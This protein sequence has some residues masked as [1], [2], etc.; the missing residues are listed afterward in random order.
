MTDEPLQVFGKDN[1]YS[2]Y[3]YALENGLQNQSG[4][5]RYGKCNSGKKVAITPFIQ[6]D[7]LQERRP[8]IDQMMWPE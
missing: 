4:W 6:E 3:M 5:K 2:V 7:G 1:Y 8:A